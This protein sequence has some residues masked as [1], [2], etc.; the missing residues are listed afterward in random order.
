MIHQ[1]CVGI[2]LSSALEPL[3]RL[4]GALTVAAVNAASDADASDADDASDAAGRFLQIFNCFIICHF[5]YSASIQRAAVHIHTYKPVLLRYL[6]TR[7]NVELRSDPFLGHVCV[8]FS[9]DFVCCVCVDLLC[10]SSSSVSCPPSKTVRYSTPGT[11]K[12]ALSRRIVIIQIQS[13]YEMK[14]SFD[15]FTRP[16][17]YSFLLLLILLLLLLLV[18]FLIVLFVLFDSNDSCP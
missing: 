14:P 5:Y 3:T 12:V 4:T 17:F 13:P 18:I 6:I 11:T 8:F 9:S 1:D 16:V 2:Q 10:V 15:L 7:W